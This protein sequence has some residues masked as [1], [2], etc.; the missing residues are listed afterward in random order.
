MNTKIGK[1]YETHF[2]INISGKSAFPFTGKKKE[3]LGKKSNRKWD[4]G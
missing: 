2:S 4:K 1:L 3:S